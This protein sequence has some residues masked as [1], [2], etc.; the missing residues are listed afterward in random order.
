MHA[1]AHRQKTKKKKGSGFEIVPT[2]VSVP[3]STYRC[4][5]FVIGSS[6]FP[7][8]RTNLSPFTK[9]FRGG[10]QLIESMNQ[11][12]IVLPFGGAILRSGTSITSLHHLFF[13]FSSEELL[14]VPLVFSY[15]LLVCKYFMWDQRN[16]FRLCGVRPSAS[17]LHPSSLVGKVFHCFY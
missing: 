4:H 5:I 12:F 16:D 14:C 15:L 11:F 6:G 13:G 10:E 3:F 8:K 2:C 1:H 9:D 17:C 7:S